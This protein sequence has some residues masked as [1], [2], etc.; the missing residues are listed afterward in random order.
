MDY[1][2]PLTELIEQF[3]KL[4]GIGAKSAQRLAFQMLSWDKKEIEKFANS[5][6]KASNDI[7]YC[8]EC[9]NFS[10]GGGVCN[11]CS[12]SKRDKSTVCIIASVRELATIERTH[13][14]KGL[15]HVLHGLI[16]PMDGI[17]PDNLKI[18]EL[19][20]RLS[21]HSEINEVILALSP[22]TE[23]EAT[24]LYLTRLLKPLI[25]K[26]TRLSFG[27]SVGSDIEQTDELTLAKAFE[28]RRECI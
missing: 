15:Y 7:H 24:T 4:P 23:G 18:K 26:I 25:K 6:L 22:S 13:E 1:V 28:G 16:S 10:T 3:R 21:R 9:F 2:L 17:G 27:L 12:S 11:I 14:F 5:L 20:N 19:L 8:P